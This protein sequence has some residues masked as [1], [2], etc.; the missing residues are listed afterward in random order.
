MAWRFDWSF[1]CPNHGL[2]LEAAC[3]RCHRPFAYDV[4]RRPTQSSRV[5]QLAGCG[6]Q[7]PPAQAGIGVA[8]RPCGHQFC[9]LPVRP[10]T[11]RIAQAHRRVRDVCSGSPATVHVQN[12]S[13]A[14]WRVELASVVAIVTQLAEP[15]D[16]GELGVAPLAAFYDYVAAGRSLGRSTIWQR[17]ADPALLAAVVPTAVELLAA[18]SPC[19]FDDGLAPLVRRGFETRFPSPNDPYRYLGVRGLTLQAWARVV[20]NR[21]SLTT[22]IRSRY[23]GT[24]NP[25][26]RAGPAPAKAVARGVRRALR[27]VPPRRRHRTSP[28]IL[29]PGLRCPA[30]KG[31]YVEVAAGLGLPRCDN[32]VRHMNRLLRDRQEADE[33]YQ[34]L[35]ETARWLDRQAWTVDYGQQR[36]S[37]ADLTVIADRDWHWACS[38]SGIHMDCRSG[39]RHSSRWLWCALTGG[40]PELA[41]SFAHR[42]DRCERATYVRFVNEALPTLQPALVA[43]ATTEM[44]R[45]N[46]VGPVRADLSG[47]E[48]SPQ[49]DADHIARTAGFE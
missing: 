14:Q 42:T 33:F 44:Q 39:P 43:I 10:T 47:W 3:P 18:P 31:S 36:R 20:G 49:P 29:L 25:T 32:L 15:D 34:A 26:R 12:V 30:T 17:S 38:T 16:L 1:A 45:R 41:P 35:V 48:P 2:L 6:N 46:L 8:C 37:L 40:E 4:N 5:P 28:T 7:A 11:D 13:A 23:G 21:Q 27:T 22:R 19:E 9:D 24:E